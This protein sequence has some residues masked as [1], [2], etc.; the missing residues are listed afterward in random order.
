M[1]F[2]NTRFSNQMILGKK[3]KWINR[4]GKGERGGREKRREKE[5]EKR[6]KY[7]YDRFLLTLGLSH[8]KECPIHK[9]LF[10]WV[11]LQ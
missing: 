7:M 8:S 1:P 3:G 11:P 2:Y 10:L 9:T 5:R 6:I 4:E